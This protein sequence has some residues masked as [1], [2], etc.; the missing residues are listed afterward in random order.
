M[1]IS[2]SSADASHQGY[3]DP[4]AVLWISLHWISAATFLPSWSVF[5]NPF[6]DC[7]LPQSSVALIFVSPAERMICSRIALLSYFPVP[8]L[9]LPTRVILIQV[10]YFT[11]SYT[12]SQ[13]PSF[14]YLVDLFKSFPGLFFLC[15]M[16][17][18]IFVWSANRYVWPNLT[19]EFGLR[20]EPCCTALVVF[21]IPDVVYLSYK[22]L[23]PTIQPYSSSCSL[24]WSFKL[25]SF[26]ICLL[27][28]TESM[29]LLKSR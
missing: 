4:N 20:S 5:S 26:P 24:S 13:L 7:P 16:A 17:A 6:L 9:I 29:A 2:T 23:D 27:Y 22:P 8:Q 25:S 14:A 11:M 10:Q 18:L 1:A 28:R 12:D 21:L 19:E 15:C 3:F